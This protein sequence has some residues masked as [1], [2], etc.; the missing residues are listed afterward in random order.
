MYEEILQAIDHTALKADTTWLD[1]Q[2]LCDEAINH[3]TA[4]V[5]IPPSYVQ[6]AADYVQGRMPICTVIGFP[7]G[8]QTTAVKVQEAREALQSGAEE[9]D[10]VINIGD[11][12]NGDWERVR[13]ELAALRDVCRD[14]VLKVIIETCCLSTKEKIAMCQ[15]IT[16]TGAD[17]IKTSTGFGSAGAAMADILLFKAHIGPQVQIKAAGGIKTIEQAQAYLA[18]GV[19]RLGSS[20]LVSLIDQLEA[21]DSSSKG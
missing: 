12:K 10:M 4:S 6:R 8:Y 14:K 18:Q 5:C 11:V 7:H 21:Q 1:I 20:S 3:R 17:F 9:I 15:L 19:S 13:Q 2:R 16:E